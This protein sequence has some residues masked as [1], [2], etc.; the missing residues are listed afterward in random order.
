MY[1][2]HK[3]RKTL[4]VLGVGLVAVTAGTI[5]YVK[6]RKKREEKGLKKAVKPGSKADPSLG[7]S[8]EERPSDLPASQKPGQE[9]ARPFRTVPED[10]DHHGGD[11]TISV[12][13]SRRRPF[14]KALSLKEILDD[15]PPTGRKHRDRGSSSSSNQK[16]QQKDKP[17]IKPSEVKKK[18]TDGKKSKKSDRR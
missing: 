14:K 10:S 8:T 7:K 11:S 18:H 17:K 13:L 2:L 1:I 15:A 3:Y 5:Y 12:S 6:Y 4:I 9:E 16:Y